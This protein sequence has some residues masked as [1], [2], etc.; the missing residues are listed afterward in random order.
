M[1]S[2][3]QKPDSSAPPLRGAPIV[4]LKD[5]HKAFGAFEVIKGI[6]FDVSKGEV[7]CIIGPSGSGKSTLI[8]CINGLSPIQRGSITVQGQEVNDPKLDKLALRKKVGIVFQQ[9]NLFPHKTALENVM[10]A[11]LK[12]L[13]EPKAEVE[14]RAR[15]LIA[16]VR[17]TGKEDAYPGQLSGGQQQRVAIARSLAMRPDVMLFDEVTAALDPETVKEVLVTIKELAADGMTCILVTHEMGFAREVADHIY[18]TDK[19]VI[20][21]HGPPQEFFNQAK[22]PRTRQFLSQVLS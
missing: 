12:V 8:R 6:S 9:Y 7:V 13:R 16:K 20:V 18:F 21:E 11:P 19:G 14:A 3:Q 4:S 22:D 2:D 15:A 17:L 10:M 5:V 1:P